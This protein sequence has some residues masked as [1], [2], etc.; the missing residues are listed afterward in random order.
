MLNLLK[1]EYVEIS[2][3]SKDVVEHRLSIKND[4]G[5]VFDDLHMSKKL[6]AT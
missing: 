5:V 6:N 2:L 3:F 1:K 4:I